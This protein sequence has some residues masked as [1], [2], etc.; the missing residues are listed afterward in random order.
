MKQILLIYGLTTET[1]TAIMML[2]RNTKVKVCSP[3][4][5]TAYFDIVA[6]ALQEDPYPFITLG[7]SGGVMVSKLD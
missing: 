7:A 3:D 6:G 5:N 2:Y 4:G 1:V